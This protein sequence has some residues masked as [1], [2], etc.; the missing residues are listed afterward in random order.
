MKN[1]INMSERRAKILVD[2]KYKELKLAYSKTT[3]N[4]NKS[5]KGWASHVAKT[6]DESSFV[7]DMKKLPDN[8]MITVLSM[9]ADPKEECLKVIHSFI[10]PKKCEIKSIDTA[11]CFSY[12]FFFR[13]FQYKKTEDFNLLKEIMA[14]TAMAIVDT[15]TDSFKSETYMEDM[16][17]TLNGVGVAIVAVTLDEEKDHLS[18][19]VKTFI[20]KND[21]NG[22][23]LDSYNK[24]KGFDYGIAPGNAQRSKSKGEE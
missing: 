23:H 6:L 17:L 8:K 20:G 9:I 5:R 7:F 4:N 3:H 14:K 13:A 24:L 2:R 19:V 11:I 18:Y 10:K 1:L 12:H 21:L 15:D 16:V 22:R